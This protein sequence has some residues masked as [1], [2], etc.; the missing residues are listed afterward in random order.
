MIRYIGR[1]FLLMIPTLIAIS[2]LS[3]LI[4]EAPPGDFLDSYIANLQSFGE[5]VDPAQITAL[6][7]RYGLGQPIYVRYFKWMWGILHGDL[8]R[9][10]EW[11]QPVARLIAQRLPWSVSISLVAFIFVY[12][13][14]IPIGTISATHQYS[15]RDYFFTFIGFI[16]IAIPNFLLALIILYFY[17]VYTGNVVLGLFSSQFQLAPWSLAKFVDLLK[18]LWMPAIIVGT[19]GTCGLIRVMRANLLDELQKPYVMVARAKGLTERKLLYK[20]PFRIAI[21]PVVSTIGWTLPGLV[22]GELLVSLVLGIPTLAPLFLQSLLS[23]DMFLAGSIIFI[24]SF[25]TVIGTLISDILL[26][27]VDPRIKGSI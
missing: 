21:N 7:I 5:F 14:G 2:V 20:Y 9:S 4:I 27:W 6:E 1:R 10:M 26:A 12:A 23:Q 3:F 8:G 18:H 24:L 19:A 15:I 13:V 25:L 11:N 16:G 22:S 17:F